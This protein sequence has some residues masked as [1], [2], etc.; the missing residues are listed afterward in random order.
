MPDGGVAAATSSKRAIAGKRLLPSRN[1]CSKSSFSMSP[2]GAF[3]VKT[4]ADLCGRCAG[5]SSRPSAFPW[6]SPIANP[7]HPVNP[8]RKTLCSSGSPRES[9][10]VFLVS[11]VA[12]T[13]SNVREAGS[14]VSMFLLCGFHLATNLL[15]FVRWG[16]GNGYSCMGTERFGSR[17]YS[18][19]TNRRNP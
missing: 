17:E 14:H 1:P 16:G 19:P 7:V 6:R 5:I 2:A 8:V 3:T 9:F 12:S 11:F 4:F 10:F 15:P 18:T 13:L